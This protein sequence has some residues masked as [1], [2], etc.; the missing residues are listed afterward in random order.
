MPLPTHITIDNTVG[1]GKW[2]EVYLDGIAQTCVVEAHTVEGWLIRYQTDA[3]GN[4][5][6]DGDSFKRERLTGVVTAKEITR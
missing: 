5:V 3:K 1:A 4:V 6:R 2:V